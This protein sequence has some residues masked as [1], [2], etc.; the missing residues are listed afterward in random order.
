MRCLGAQGQETKS[1]RVLPPKLLRTSKRWVESSKIQRRSRQESV[2]RFQAGR[3]NSGSKWL[4]QQKRHLLPLWSPGAQSVRFAIDEVMVVRSSGARRLFLNNVKRRDL[5]KDPVYS[6]SGRS[7]WLPP[8][9]RED[10]VKLFLLPD[11]RFLICEMGVWYYVFW[12]PYKHVL[13]TSFSSLFLIL[14]YLGALQTLQELPFHGLA[15]F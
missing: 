9:G 15:N 14:W 3:E 4:K 11:P 12:G 7:P 13:T 2:G 10:L 5:A 8:I 1:A 6:I